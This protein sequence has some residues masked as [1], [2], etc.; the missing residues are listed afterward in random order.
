MSEHADRFTALIDTD[1]LVTSMARDILLTFAEAGF[2]RLALSTISIND[3]FPRAFIRANGPDKARAAERVRS[4][5]CEVFDDAL[6]IPNDPLIDS[7]K[8]RD[9][10]DR[11]ILA[12]AIQASANVIVTWNLKDFDIEALAPFDIEAKSPDDFI[13]DTVGIYHADAYAILQ[14]MRIDWQKPAMDPDAF[15]TALERARLVDTAA[16]LHP[17]KGSI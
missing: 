10:D 8:M 12:A 1:V 7:L 9:P 4:T 2:F 5:I 3:E 16:L 11:H 15:L 6:V 14:R 17:V 13:A